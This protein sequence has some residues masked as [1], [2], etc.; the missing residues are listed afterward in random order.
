MAFFPDLGFFVATG[1]TRAP[2]RGFFVALGSPAVLFEAVSVCSVMVVILAPRRWNKP[3]RRG[4]SGDE[5]DRTGAFQSW[6]VD[7]CRAAS[8]GSCSASKVQEA[9]DSRNRRRKISTRS[10]QCSRF[11]LFRPAKGAPML[12]ADVSPR[13]CRNARTAVV[14]WR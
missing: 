2:T 6:K 10:G 1:A 9:N 11:D 7:W 3:L 5:D 14:G 8:H 4:T 12:N 13:G